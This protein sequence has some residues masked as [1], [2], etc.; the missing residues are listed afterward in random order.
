M[1]LS[2]RIS[3]GVVLLISIITI[4]IMFFVL[5][6][7]QNSFEE[8]NLN[9]SSTLAH[10]LAEAILNN[11]IEKNASQVKETLR[12]TASFD[13]DIKYIIVTDFN[14]YLLEHALPY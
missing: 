5:R 9:W 13:P 2:H 12:R 7:I 4:S 1:R 3:L 10:T 6:G 8:N 11:V 14:N